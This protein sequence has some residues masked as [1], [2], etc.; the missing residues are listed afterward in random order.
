MKIVPYNAEYHMVTD[1]TPHERSQVISRYNHIPPFQLLPNFPGI[2]APVV[3]AIPTGGGVL[4]PFR[5]WRWVVEMFNCEV[6]DAIVVRAKTSFTPT[7]QEYEDM[8]LGWE[9]TPTPRH[10]QISAAWKILHYSTSL[11]ELATRSG[12]TLIMYLVLRTLKQFGILN[13]ALVIVP[14]ALLVRQGIS[15]I[16]SYGNLTV[17]GLGG[18]KKIDPSTDVHISTFQSLN[19]IPEHQIKEYNVICCDEAHTASCTTINR[20]LKN[21]TWDVIR[22]GFSGTLP[23][24]LTIEESAVAKVLGPVINK[25]KSKD[26][27]DADILA[28]PHII[29]HK[30]KYTNH[31]SLLSVGYKIAEDIIG[32]VVD[33]ETALIKSLKECMASY[34][35]ELLMGAASDGKRR[36]IY[37]IISK[38]GN[39]ILFTVSVGG[40]HLLANEIRNLGMK[41]HVITGET[42]MR[43]RNLMLED[44]N[45]PNQHEQTIIVGTYEIISTGITF[46]RVS[47]G[48]LVDTTTSPIRILQS[49]GR[50]MLK[51]E[52]KDSFELHDICEVYPTRVGTK[53]LNERKKIYAREGYPVTDVTHSI[54]W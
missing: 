28:T 11:S 4:I 36:V 51:G 38:G 31:T 45:N 46:K 17:S 7:L 8:V 16:T 37:D 39:W 49:M 23:K 43:L 41:C 40:A 22:W 30:I 14:T 26:M 13:K 19:K 12:K 48:V 2:P 35:W 53:H 54:D 10:Y 32:D 24:P 33:S 42:S 5:T 34:R 1:L 44:I 6:D 29:T 52:G 18:G 25:I 27:V 9:I 21:V 47:G 50:L 20:F 15:D 3:Y